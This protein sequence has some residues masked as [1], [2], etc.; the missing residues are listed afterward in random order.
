MQKQV[1][2]ITGG[3]GLIGNAFSERMKAEGHEVRLLGRAFKGKES[4][5]KYYW[6]LER[7]EIDEK[8]LSG[9]TWLVHLA[10]EP[11]AGKRWTTSRKKAIVDSRVKSTELL[12]DAIERTGNKPKHVVSASAVGYYGAVT[13]EQ[14]FTETDVPGHDFLAKVCVEWEKQASRF[15]EELNIPVSV[16]RIGVVFS[17]DG[18]A[19]RQILQPMRMGAGINLGSGRQWLPWIHIDDLVSMIHFLLQR[20][21]EGTYNAVAPQTVTFSDV[22]REAAKRMNRFVFPLGIPK[23]LL[24]LA[25]GEQAAIVV[26]GSR[27][28]PQKVQ[29]NGFAFSY[30]HIKS[31]LGDILG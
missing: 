19:L 3:S 16:V 2:L 25:L 7:G 18:G 15:K 20:E 8:A 13:S 5:G 31:A 27:V 4:E 22:N 30:P 17:K 11:V 26:E 23:F 21:L 10:G 12:L 29:K 28:T 9:I 1:V 14:V 24:E 6:N